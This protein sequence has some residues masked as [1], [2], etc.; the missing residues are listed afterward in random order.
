MA[1]RG[2]INYYIEPYGFIY[3]FFHTMQ[4][5][6]NAIRW[7]AETGRQLLD[8][9]GLFFFPTGRGE[10]TFFAARLL[11]APPRGEMDQQ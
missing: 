9:K 4:E 3:Y 5:R 6:Q 11:V 10:F 1:R 8:H 2:K 7:T